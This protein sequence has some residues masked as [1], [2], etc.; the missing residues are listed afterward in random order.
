MGEGEGWG[1]RGAGTAS[2]SKAAATATAVGSERG[3]DLGA[4][5]VYAM[6]RERKAQRGGL[7]GPFSCSLL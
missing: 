4:T 1:A 5:W 6:W 3:P 7:A 2:S